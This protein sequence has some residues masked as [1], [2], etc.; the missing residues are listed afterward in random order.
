MSGKV[1]LVGAGPGD[2]ELLTLK[3]WRILRSAD[4]VLHDDL[5][6][7]EILSL[8]AESAEVLNVGKRCGRKSLTQDDINARMLR[9]AGEGNTVVRL[10]GGDPLIFGRAGEE[11]EALRAAGV[12]FEVVP[13]VTAAL[14]AAASA[15]IPLTDR[16]LA[17]RL[18]FLTGHRCREDAWE[19]LHGWTRGS[20]IVLY[21]P[22]DR[23]SDF[24][25]ELRVAGMP[26]KTPCIAVSEASTPR[27]QIHRATLEELQRA[28]RW[29][30]PTVLIIGH[31]ASAARTNTSRRRENRSILELAGD[32]Q[33]TQLPALR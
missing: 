16:R 4:V 15:E 30:S 3:G 18:V 33:V 10:K 13:G 28:P 23:V 12:E 8:A 2:P 26:P 1:Y 31:V 21:M 32:A 24:A 9:A 7:P 27:E 19:A 6:S 20:T 17:S 25:R 14:A 22:G 11:M 5:V 29:P